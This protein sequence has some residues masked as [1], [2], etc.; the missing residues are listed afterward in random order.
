MAG[1]V[2][3]ALQEKQQE[4]ARLLKAYNASRRAKWEEAKTR[5]PEIE[6]FADRLRTCITPE[7]TINY[8]KRHVIM[9]APKDIRYIALRIIDK[10]CNKRALASGG[11]ELDDPLPPQTSVFF[12]CK[13]L[14]GLR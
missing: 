9:S 3:V 2:P 1:R 10:H 11:Q 5:F 14:L 6:D 13:D 8:V 12:V 7:G 4:R